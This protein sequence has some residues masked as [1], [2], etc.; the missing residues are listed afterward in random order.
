MS[1]R[2]RYW[3][4]KFCPG[5]IIFYLNRTCRVAAESE[6]GS[7]EGHVPPGHVPLYQCD[8]MGRRRGDVFTVP[9]DDIIAPIRER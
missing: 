2:I 9:L 6:L 8:F 5:D 3:S 7:F 1:K 4:G